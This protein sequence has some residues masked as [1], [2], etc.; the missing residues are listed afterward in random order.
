MNNV[1]IVDAFVTTAPFSGNP[2]GVCLLDEWMSDQ[3]M[4]CVAAEF[5]HSETAFVVKESNTFTIRYFTPNVEVPFCGHATLAAAFVLWE[6][7]VVSVNQEIMFNAKGGK[8]KAIK[9]NNAILID[10]PLIKVKLNPDIDRQT[11][12][13]LS[14]KPL[15]VYHYE[16]SILCELSSEEDVVNYKPDSQ[17]I[18]Q[19]PYDVIIITAESRSSHVDF[20]SRVFAPTLGIE[21]DPATGIAQCMLGP[22]WANKLNKNRLN[23]Y[24]ASKRGGDFCIV[25]Q[26]NRIQL[27]GKTT[28]VFSGQ[29]NKK[30]LS[31]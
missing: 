17:L 19:L 26:K 22:I 21:E 24:Q 12:S 1:F 15:T 6:K 30:L 25:V 4:Q 2:A 28:L 16:N 10:V 14:L 29:L 9:E 31:E 7:G 8:I 3:W 27:L 20:V 13:H 23:A 5:K 11:F 18:A